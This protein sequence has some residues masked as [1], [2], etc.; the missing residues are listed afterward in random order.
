[1]I[2]KCSNKAKSNICSTYTSLSVLLFILIY[3][4]VFTEGYLTYII[5][6]IWD[7]WNFIMHFG[8]L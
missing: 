7:N 3:V 8:Y 4:Y 5:S 1:M 6:I 2:E